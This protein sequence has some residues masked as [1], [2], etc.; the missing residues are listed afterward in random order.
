LIK[1]VHD[2]L[3]F[4]LRQFVS[5]LLFYHLA[6]ILKIGVLPTLISPACY[7][8]KLTSLVLARTPI[9][10][11]INQFDHHLTVHTRNQFSSSP[12]MAWHFFASTS[13]AA[14]SAR[15]FS[16]RRSSDSNSRICFLS[17]WRLRA[18]SFTTLVWC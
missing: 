9:Y 8:D 12:Q 10:R 5:R 16:S 13:K 6:L 15:A 18:F 2:S 17:S 14:V 1:N 11:F 3:A 4:Q 7:T